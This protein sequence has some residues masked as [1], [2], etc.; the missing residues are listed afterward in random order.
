MINSRIILRGS[1]WLVDLD[2]TVGH[3]Q[4]KRRPCIV[5]SANT[6]N[7]GYAGLVLILPITSQKRDLYWYVSLAPSEGGLDKQSYIICDQVRSLSIQRF[8]SK[9]LG[10]ASDYVI[11]QIEERLKVLFH[12]VP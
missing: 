2:P 4:A 11:D 10:M 12:I 9:M 7:Q 5:V 6:Y 3:E 8:S 1:I